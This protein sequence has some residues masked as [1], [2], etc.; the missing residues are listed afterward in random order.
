M[1]WPRR[2]VRSTSCRSEVSSQVD[3]RVPVVVRLATRR[4]GPVRVPAA[5]PRP[6]AAGTGRQLTSAGSSSE[7][8]VSPRQQACSTYGDG[9]EPDPLQ[10]GFAW[11][12]NRHTFATSFRW[13]RT[14]AALRPSSA[15]L[16][17]DSAGD[18]E[19]LWELRPA[20]RGCAGRCSGGT[21]SRPCPCHS[22]RAPEAVSLLQELVEA[23]PDHDGYRL[24]LSVTLRAPRTVGAVRVGAERN[25]S[26]EHGS[27]RAGRCQGQAGRGRGG[28]PPRGARGEAGVPSD[29]GASEEGARGNRDPGGLLLPGLASSSKGHSPVVR[30]RLERGD[31]PP[32][33]CERAL[34]GRRAVPRAPGDVRTMSRNRTSDWT[35]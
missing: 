35:P 34:P 7:V 4:A 5:R 15:P 9:R 2:S 33:E 24:N 13:H 28:P 18:E 23:F 8:D 27:R 16:G 3:L 22:D 26:E 1:A 31:G 10:E 19:I 25:R 6:S 21:V 14:P 20:R 29:D 17:L 12:T 30:A 32:G 11:T